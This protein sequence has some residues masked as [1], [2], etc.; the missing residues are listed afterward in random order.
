MLD[1]SR[2]VRYGD[3]RRKETHM[4]EQPSRA[5]IGAA[6][7]AAATKWANPPANM[8]AKLPRY[9][10]PRDTPKNQ[11]KRENC[12]ICHGYHEMPSIH[13]D[14]MGH[15]DVTLALIDTDP[16]WTWEPCAYDETGA[17]QIAHMNGRLVLWGWLELHGV[18]R[19][20]VGTCDD[21]KTDPEKELVGDLLRNGAMRF[22]IGTALWSKADA[23]DEPPTNPEKKPSKPATKPSENGGPTDGYV[24]SAVL[25]LRCN[26]LSPTQ[27]TELLNRWPL[28]LKKPIPDMIPPSVAAELERLLDSIENPEEAAQSAASDPCSTCG[29]ATVC[30]LP[31][32]AAVLDPQCRHY[33]GEEE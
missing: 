23:H 24:E 33:E 31:M 2:I 15:A 11:R 30:P 1:L 4:S 26:A 29:T 8:I 21:T 19:L 14:Y 18:R 16:M 28:K 10:G 22:G 20:A 9:T 25:K 17:P 27:K 6:L 13:L 3:L 7:H 12:H 32:A 5:I